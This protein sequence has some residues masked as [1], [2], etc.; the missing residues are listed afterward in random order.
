MAAG[1]FVFPTATCR[2]RAD[3]SGGL[4]SAGAIAQPEQR[5]VHRE[6]RDA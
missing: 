2:Q 3:M 6:S 1:F 4:K 5:H